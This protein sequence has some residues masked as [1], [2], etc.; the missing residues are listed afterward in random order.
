MIS[1]FGGKAVFY[2]DH[3]V[4]ICRPNARQVAGRVAVDLYQS[5]EEGMSAR[6]FVDGKEVWRY[7]SIWE[8][9]VPFFLRNFLG[10]QIYL[11]PINP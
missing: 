8:R 7:I 3:D 11:T 1:A 9:V 2:Y 4:P 10:S 5:N 6:L